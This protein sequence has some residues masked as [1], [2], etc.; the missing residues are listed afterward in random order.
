MLRNAANSGVHNW[1]TSY[2][3]NVS[4][5]ALFQVS[6]ADYTSLLDVSCAQ[7]ARPHSGNITDN[8][9]HLVLSMSP[10]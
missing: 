5:R 3:K 4:L 10:T 8:H 9:M 6:P 7:S 1:V 2:V